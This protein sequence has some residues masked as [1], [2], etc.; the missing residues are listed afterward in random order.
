MLRDQAKQERAITC[1]DGAD[2]GP[3]LVAQLL[4]AP[5]IGNR[6]HAHGASQLHIVRD[7]LGQEPVLAGCE[8]DFMEGVVDLIDPTQVASRDSAVVVALDRL[9][10]GDVVRRSRERHAFDGPRL[11]QLT[12]LVDLLNLLRREIADGSAAVGGTS[13]DAEPL[14]T[15]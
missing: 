6:V 14:L 7:R 8:E 10:R 3:V 13:D 15:A 11:E 5:R 9:E 1:F 2:H 12:Q 4:K